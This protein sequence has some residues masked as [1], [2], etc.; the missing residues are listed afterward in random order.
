MGEQQ[1]PGPVDVAV[2]G[3][4]V[5][6]ASVARAARLRGLDVVVIDPEPGA[7]ASRGNAGLVVPGYCLPMAT[8][9]N[10]RAGLRGALGHDAAVSVGR[11][12]SPTTTGWLARF[13]LSARPGRVRS[14]A[15]ATFELADRSRRLYDELADAGLDLGLRPT[16]WLWAFRTASGPRAAA[17]VVRD[18][19][20]AGSNGRMVGPDEARALEPA[21]TPDVTAGVW[22]PDEGVLDPARATE[23]LLRDGAERGVRLLREPVVAAERD[24][25]W[26][27]SLRT[28]TQVVTARWVVL[29]A[30][31]SSR[32]VGALLG[33]RVPVEAGHG[34]SL[35]IPTSGPPLR[36]ALMD[37]DAHVVVSPLP[38]AVRITGGMQLGGRPD[39]SRSAATVAGLRDAATGLVPALAALADGTA[40]HGARPMTTGGLPLLGRDRRVAN[41]VLA[42]GHGTLGMTLAPVTGE[43]VS[44]LIASGSGRRTKGA[45]G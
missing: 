21:L 27:R 7:G 11:P 20:R 3:G 26:I 25:A 35:T 37:A 31:A 40:W 22:F 32:A 9:A 6:G 1:A 29:A 30:G 38:G 13:A 8:P 18:L 23:V 5:I 14:T 34:W 28:T 43:I 33:A 4:G 45:V 19:E 39:G 15:R 10:L 24:G 2:I 41:L 42:T 12:L 16:G 36:R 17:A 44:E